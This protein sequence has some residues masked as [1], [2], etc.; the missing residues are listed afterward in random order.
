M[1]SCTNA[2]DF[3]NHF[4]PNS[5][6]SGSDEISKLN[7]LFNIDNNKDKQSTCSKKM[8]SKKIARTKKK[9][10]E[11]SQKTTQKNFCLDQ[12][13]LGMLIEYLT[14]PFANEEKTELLKQISESNKR[15]LESSNFKN[16]IDVVNIVLFKNKNIEELKKYKLNNSNY[17]NKENLEM[18]SLSYVYYFMKYLLIK[19]KEKTVWLDS[20]MQDKELL[21][22]MEYDISSSIFKKI[23]ETTR[24]P[25]NEQF[26]YLDKKFLSTQKKIILESDGTI[27]ILKQKNVLYY[28]NIENLLKNLEI[29]INYINE[30]ITDLQNENVIKLQNENNINFIN[31][32]IE[33]NNVL[34]SNVCNVEIISNNNNI[35]L[36][37]NIQIKNNIDKLITNNKNNITNNN[38][39]EYNSDNEIYDIDL[40][41]TPEMDFNLDKDQKDQDDKEDDKEQV[42][43]NKIKDNNV[44]ISKVVDFEIT[45]GVKNNIENNSEN[46]VK[47][48]NNVLDNE[49][50]F[51]N[52]DENNNEFH[53]ALK[54]MEEKYN[55]MINTINNTSK[56]T[57][58]HRNNMQGLKNILNSIPKNYYLNTELYEQ[59]DEESSYK[60]DLFEYDLLDLNKQE[61]NCNIM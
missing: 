21:N 32:S 48:E 34:Q 57:N 42:N 11:K 52:N 61:D 53:L 8:L 27:T 50:I 49:D 17:S 24:I 6:I 26:G 7:R 45:Q 46:N 15:K 44:I 39:E 9:Q 33:N 54:N 47:E 28:S 2:S 1:I 37:N 25:Y 55:N 13:I 36:N 41:K 43:S 12:D 31:N 5:H 38:I 56:D 20:L 29:N 14:K 3:N 4:T 35:T 23:N 19:N 16:I 30:D 60:N 59:E 40:L 18:S 10:K 22:N 51:N 58:G